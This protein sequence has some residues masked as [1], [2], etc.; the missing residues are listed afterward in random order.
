MQP[1]G[2]R[3]LAERIVAAIEARTTALRA[4]GEKFPTSK[5]LQT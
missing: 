3:R 5:L 1:K 2:T 4:N